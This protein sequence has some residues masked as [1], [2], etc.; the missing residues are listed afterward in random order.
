L[1]VAFKRRPAPQDED[2]LSVDIE[3]AQSCAKALKRCRVASLHAGRIRDVGL[4]VVV[5]EAPHANITGV[6]REEE[7]RTAANRLAYELARQ[8]RLIPP[9]QD[10]NKP[11]GS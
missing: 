5:D 2:G 9:Q 4:D 7:D 10:Q 8:A 6:P 11:T 3:S 1:P